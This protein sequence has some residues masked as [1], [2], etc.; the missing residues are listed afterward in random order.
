MP[1]GLSRL[2]EL[3][4]EKR[5][6][7]RRASPARLEDDDLPGRCRPLAS[8]PA[9]PMGL[10][11]LLDPLQSTLRVLPAE[12][13]TRGVHSRR[14]GREPVRAIIDNSS[15]FEQ[16]FH[17]LCLNALEAMTAGGELTVRVVDLC[18]AGGSPLL[19]EFSVPDRRPSKLHT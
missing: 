8:A 3:E 10:V 14:V 6:A 7:E 11:D 18:N 5:R 12:R 2:K 19:V 15:Q 13:T 1:R 4:Q 9:Q 16:L 17:H